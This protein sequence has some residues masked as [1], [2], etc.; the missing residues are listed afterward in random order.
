[1]SKMIR[2]SIIVVL[3]WL[4][5]ME[6]LFYKKGSL[7]IPRLCQKYARIPFLVIASRDPALAGAKA[8]QS[9][10]NNEQRDRRVVPRHKSGTPRDD[11]LWLLGLS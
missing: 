5:D 8:W 1:M 11:D 2:I 3:R 10:H 6:R 7:D 9:H 4:A